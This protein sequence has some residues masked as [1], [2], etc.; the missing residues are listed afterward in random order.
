MHITVT[1]C[2]TPSPPSGWHCHRNL[3]VT[4]AMIVCVCGMGGYAL[5]PLLC[6]RDP[7]LDSEVMDMFVC[8]S[9]DGALI[10]CEWLSTF[11]AGIHAGHASLPVLLGFPMA[12]PGSALSIRVAI[13]L[14]WVSSHFQ[15][16]QTHSTL[17]RDVT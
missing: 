7:V 11:P 4:P 13:A 10:H 9:M 5:Y 8:Y 12:E 16:K 1:D 14:L 6:R 15:V 3:H 2:P 17:H